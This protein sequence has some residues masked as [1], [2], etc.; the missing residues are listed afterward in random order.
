MIPLALTEALWIVMEPKVV[1]RIGTGNMPETKRTAPRA[2][3]ASGGEETA[4]MP[5]R[6]DA[7]QKGGEMQ[8]N[9]QMVAKTP[10]A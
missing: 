8:G 5:E 7:Q 3:A 9:P 6:G 2:S 10:P 1:L 4:A